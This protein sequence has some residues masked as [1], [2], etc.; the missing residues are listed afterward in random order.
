VA[1]SS[2]SS[3]G[4]DPTGGPLLDALRLVFSSL[5]LMA[6]SVILGG[7]LLAANLLLPIGDADDDFFDI[8]VPYLFRL[9]ATKSQV[10]L[11]FTAFVITLALVGFGGGKPLYESF[12]ENF[13]IDPGQWLAICTISAFFT[14]AW[15][16]V[17]YLALLFQFRPEVQTTAHNEIIDQLQERGPGSE[18][19][20][21]PNDEDRSDTESHSEPLINNDAVRA[22]DNNP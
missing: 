10:I 4:P 16:F 7:K 22:G 17:V 13:G 9:K 1:T 12:K 2:Q 3:P 15:T 18:I 6:V 5:V 21:P 11:G 14:V 19:V 8:R 20:V